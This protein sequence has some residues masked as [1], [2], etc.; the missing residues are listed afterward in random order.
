MS[1][2]I[3]FG[4]L[5]EQTDVFDFKNSEIFY[6][7]SDYVCFVKDKIGTDHVFELSITDEGDINKISLACSNTDKA[8]NFISY[9]REVI[10]VYSP[11]ENADEIIVSLTES[12]KIKTEL[13]YYDTQWYSWCIYADKNGLYFSVTNKKFAVQSETA[14]TLKPNDKS[15]F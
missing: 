2:E 15:G 14:L 12:G 5:S 8:E 11:K 10:N 7:N 6:E 3:F 9:I 1:P 4:R 13:N